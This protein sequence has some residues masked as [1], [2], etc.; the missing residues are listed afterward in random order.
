MANKYMKRCST[1]LATRR[2]QIKTT[3]RYQ[4]ISIKRVKTVVTTVHAGEHVGD[5]PLAVVVGLCTGTYSGNQ[6]G[7]FL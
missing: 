6:L 3:V 7:R 1:S 2:M 4:Y 5:D